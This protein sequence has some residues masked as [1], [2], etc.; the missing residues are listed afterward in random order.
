MELLPR[1][2][3]L[4]WIKNFIYENVINIPG[5]RNYQNWEVWAGEVAQQL[6]R[7]VGLP[8]SL[9]QIP[10]NHMVAYDCLTIVP[11][12]LMPSS[13]LHGQA[14]KWWTWVY[15]HKILRHIK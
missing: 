11:S 2:C 7:V 13:L 14:C 12:N 1:I 8:E 15:I 9:E 4:Y 6:K 5:V 10:T 3:I